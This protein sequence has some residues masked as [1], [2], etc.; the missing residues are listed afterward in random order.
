MGFIRGQSQAGTRLDSSSSTSN[1]TN[2]THAHTLFKL[3]VSYLQASATKLPSMH[4]T[5][6]VGPYK[7]WASKRRVALLNADRTTNA[8]YDDSLTLSNGSAKGFLWKQARSS[9]CNIVEP[10]QATKKAKLSLSLSLPFYL[11][12]FAQC[13]SSFISKHLPDAKQLPARLWLSDSSCASI[14]TGSTRI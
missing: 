12:L 9:R 3:I 11:A 5:S 4:K 1:A 7:S 14:R 6:V 13:Y 8:Q 2:Q 10:F